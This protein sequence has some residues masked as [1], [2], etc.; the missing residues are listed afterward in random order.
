MSQEIVQRAMQRGIAAHQNGDVAT[1]EAAYREAL[2]AAPEDAGI[3]SLLGLAIT[4]QGR[5]EEGLAFLESALRRFPDH[6]GLVLNLVEALVPMGAFARAEVLLRGVIAIDKRNPQAWN[7]LGDVLAHLG[8]DAEAQDAWVA[9][10]ELDHTLPNPATKIARLLLGGGQAGEAII[11]TGPAFEKYPHHPGLR[12]V[13]GEALSALREWPELETLA[14]QWVETEPGDPQGWRHLARATYEQ[15]R[16]RQAKEAFH[17]SLTLTDP[18]AL[19]W[20]AYAG[21]CLHALEL[22]AAGEALDKAE[23]LDPA[24]PV[25]ALHRATLALYHGRF[26]EAEAAC[27]RCLAADPHNAGAYTLLTRLKKGQLEPEDVAQLESLLNSPTH[28]DFR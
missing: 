25:V 7:R 13:R 18:S 28:Y 16:V 14:K 17:T 1:A 3:V 9:A 15:G 21:I 5:A 20:A 27:R 26:A 12:H 24:L 11:A 23:A 2:S 19:E 8:K 4:H 22:P 6:P 10:L